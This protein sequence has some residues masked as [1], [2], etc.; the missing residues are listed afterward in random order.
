MKKPVWSYYEQRCKKVKK[1]VLAAALSVCWMM[2][3]DWLIDWLCNAIIPAL[4]CIGTL[5][6]LVISVL[7]IWL[8]LLWR[9]F[10]IRLY[11]TYCSTGLVMFDNRFLCSLPCTLNVNKP[12]VYFG[13]FTRKERVIPSRPVSF[14]RAFSPTLL[15][16][17]FS[18]LMSRY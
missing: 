14:S 12:S 5:S 6:A 17:Y 7:W 9:L 8:A 15:E 11:C 16:L 13:P 18:D 4:K 3:F 1:N 2:G 10:M